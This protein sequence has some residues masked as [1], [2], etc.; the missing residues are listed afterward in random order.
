VPLATV[1]LEE[2]KM[3]TL[4]DE[5]VCLDDTYPV[6][7]ADGMADIYC[8]AGRT[9][10]LFFRWQKFNGI[11]IRV[12]VGEVVRPEVTAAEWAMFIKN[13]GIEKGIK[14][15]LCHKAQDRFDN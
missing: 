11:L 15:G 8:V 4:S 13:I 7:Q 3:S 2:V 9:H 12:M 10:I 1:V 6:I 14:A 5:V